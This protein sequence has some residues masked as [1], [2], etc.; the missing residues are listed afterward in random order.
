MNKARITSN[1]A[2]KRSFA[3]LSND[4]GF[5]MVSVFHLTEIS[6]TSCP[7]FSFAIVNRNVI[8]SPFILPSF[9]AISRD[10]P[11]V[12]DGFLGDVFVIWRH[13]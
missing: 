10:Y 7:V 3:G 1:V 9:S 4:Y 12:H 6:K 8:C 5:S 13:F 2:F 11:S